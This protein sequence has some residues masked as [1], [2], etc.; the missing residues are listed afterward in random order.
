MSEAACRA[1]VSERSMGLCEVRIDVGGVCRGVAES[2]HHRRKKGQGGAWTPSNIVD[3]CGHGTIGCHGF[4]EANP[5]T[6]RR[7]GLWLYTGS[8]A[9]TTPVQISWRGIRGWYLLHDDGSLTW[10]SET[11]LARMKP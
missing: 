7:T 11:G 10:L 8:E 9:H 5:A 1:V 6:A 3:I 4:I 2:K